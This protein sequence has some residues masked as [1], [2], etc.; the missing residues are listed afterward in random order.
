M[1][2]LKEAWASFLLF[3]QPRDNPFCDQVVPMLELYLRR[4]GDTPLSFKLYFTSK[5]SKPFLS[6][7]LDHSA[8]WENVSIW[9]P[10]NALNGP[11]NRDFPLLKT[12]EF[13]CT[14]KQ[15]VPIPSET[16]CYMGR[17]PSLHTLTIVSP[18]SYWPVDL[19]TSHITNFVTVAI[20][21]SL[22]TTYLR[23]LPSVRSFTYT[24]TSHFPELLPPLFSHPTLRSICFRWAVWT[25]RGPSLNA[26][27]N[28]LASLAMPSATSIAIDLPTWQVGGTGAPWGKNAV[29]WPHQEFLFFIQRSACTL[30]EL[31]LSNVNFN[32]IQ[33]RECLEALPTLR[34]LELD[35]PPVFLSGALVDPLTRQS[36]CT[37][38]ALLPMLARLKWRGRL[39]FSDDDFVKMVESR[40]WSVPTLTC[41]DVTFRLRKMKMSAK[42]RMWALAAGGLE[43]LIS[44]I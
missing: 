26:L 18:L 30:Q 22:A 11:G 2:S 24:S 41:V 1:L 44:E 23:R 17:A 6:T 21:L 34:T 42:S 20:P 32:A 12:L 29:T 33:L 3:V 31:I 27:H 36:S 9:F 38:A 28:F 43:V 5:E 39:L 37:E 14:N 10:P 4:S 35:E 8:R 13:G 7:L 19:K 16:M 15:Y 40:L 25:A